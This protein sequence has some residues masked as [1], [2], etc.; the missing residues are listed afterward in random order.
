MLALAELVGVDR[1][2]E[3]PGAL[4]QAAARLDAERP[5]GSTELAL[6]V[7]L[8][9]L[10]AT[11][12]RQLSA[13]TGAD[14]EAMRAAI[15][16]I[17]ARRGKMHNPATGSGGILVGRAASVGERFPGREVRVGERIASLGSLTMTPLTL[18]SVG[19]VDPASAQIP[20]R[21]R[22]VLAAG[23][24]W[25]PVPADLPLALVLAA[26]DVYGAASH[27][28]A[29]ARRGAH[30][31]VL[32]AGRAGLLA[33]AAA[34]AAVGL[35]GRVTVLDLLASSLERVARA[36][37]AAATLAVD[38]SDALATVE[39]LAGAGRGAADLTV[40]V[41]D[42]PG[43]EMAAVLATRPGGTV[44]L[45][46]MATSFSAAALGAEGVAGTARMLVGNG[47]AP[48][49]GSYALELLRENER[50]AASFAELA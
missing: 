4:P 44:L 48:D 26:L 23:A 11:S 24:P 6:D 43:C 45:F 21:G 31:L 17:V 33:A 22:A 5:A 46:S 10:D 49:R 20:V 25:A 38:A 19:P 16:D 8:L 40:V 27:T 2:L 13:S 35:H 15:A 39:A 29:L 34:Q 1:V 42:R 32:G 41:V 28:R 12:H 14:P 3:P 9:N 18:A 36:G 37:L 47:Y 50:L 30:V 7:D